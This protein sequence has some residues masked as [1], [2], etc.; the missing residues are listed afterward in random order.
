[1]DG[2]LCGCFFLLDFVLE[3]N[4]GVIPPSAPSRG[5]RPIQHAAE[6]LRAFR[7]RELPDGRQGLR[8]NNRY[9]TSQR[10]HVHI[11]LHL[12]I[13]GLVDRLPRRTLCERRFLMAFTLA[14]TRPVV[15]QAAEGIVV[16]CASALSALTGFPSTAA[17]EVEGESK[18][19]ASSGRSPHS[20][21]ISWRIS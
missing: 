6:L 12:A 16:A 9:R 14:L 11:P 7:F 15:L 20:R 18:F 21:W 10:F 1:M 13:L 4:H 5:I 8:C 17:A 3:K 2:F 19:S